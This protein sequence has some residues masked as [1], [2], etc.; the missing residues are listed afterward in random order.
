MISLLFSNNNVIT[1][2]IK[3]ARSRSS[4]GSKTRSNYGSS[5]KNYSSSNSTNSSNKNY[6]SSSANN[7]STN[8]SNKNYSSS[9]NNSS[10]NSSTNV[11][12]GSSLPFKVTTAAAIGYIIGSNNARIAANNST[13]T[14]T[15]SSNDTDNSDS[16]YRFTIDCCNKMNEYKKCMSISN[17]QEQEECKLRYQYNERCK[18][19]KCDY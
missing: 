16:M 9:A 13:S 4:G 17:A 1:V 2:T 18:N 19:L 11:G 5:S 7:S 10:A 14:T 6:S 3:M 8:N 15:S 12:S